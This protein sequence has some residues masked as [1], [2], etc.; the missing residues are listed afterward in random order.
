M[1]KVKG[2]KATQDNEEFMADENVSDLV[3]VGNANSYLYGTQTVEVGQSI[4]RIA[5]TGNNQTDFEVINND[6]ISETD[7]TLAYLIGQVDNTVTIAT[8]KVQEDNTS[9]SIRAKVTDI[10]GRVLTVQDKGA[11]ILVEVL[12]SDALVEVAEKL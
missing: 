5:D 3:G 2:V 1:Y 11:A 12:G 7:N 8:A 9:A 10:N 4:R 6:Y